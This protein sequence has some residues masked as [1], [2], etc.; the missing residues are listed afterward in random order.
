MSKA[1]GQHSAARVAVIVPCYNHAHYLPETIASVAGQTFADW[2]IVIINNGSTDTTDEVARQLIT[3]FKPR[4]IRLISQSAGGPGAGRNTGMQ[5]THA[6]FLL[7][8]DADD[9]LDARFLEKTV[10]LL[11]RNPGLGFVSTNVRFFGSEQ[12]SWSGGEPTLEDRKSVV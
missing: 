3:R 4:H 11:E 1:A 12:G 6:P 7:P 2:E 10:P 8:L 5:A 9:L